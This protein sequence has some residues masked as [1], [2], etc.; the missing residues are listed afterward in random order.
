M[1]NSKWFNKRRFCECKSPKN[2]VKLCLSIKWAESGANNTSVC[3]S[4]HPPPTAPF[5]IRIFQVLEPY[6]WYEKKIADVKFPFSLIQRAR[7]SLVSMNS[8]FLS[9]CPRLESNWSCLWLN[10]IAHRGS[11]PGEV[12]YSWIDIAYNYFF[13]WIK[14]HIKIFWKI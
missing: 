6:R 8:N 4:T 7:Y 1:V 10:P 9:L 14:E 2:I 3:C 13:L 11:R 12:S 5:L